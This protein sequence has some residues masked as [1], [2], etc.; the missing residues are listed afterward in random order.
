MAYLDGVHPS[1]VICKGCYGRI[2]WK[3]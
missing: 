3:H 2:V 1:L